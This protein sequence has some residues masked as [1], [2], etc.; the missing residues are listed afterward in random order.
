MSTKYP[1]LAQ[2]IKI[3][4]GGH[5]SQSDG[6]IVGE[7]KISQNKLATVKVF[8]GKVYLDL[9][10]FEKGHPTKAGITLNEYEFDKFLEVLEKIINSSKCTESGAFRTGIDPGFMAL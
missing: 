4:K 1:N 7:F 10:K 6:T 8:K 5:K 2:Y 9:R 3:G